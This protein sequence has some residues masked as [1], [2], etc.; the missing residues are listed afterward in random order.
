M[1]ERITAITRNIDAVI[2]S[3]NVIPV[4]GEVNMGHVFGSLKVLRQTKG[5]IE[6]LELKEEEP[7]QEATEDK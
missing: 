6:A 7:A 1:D 5:M 2:N 3:L 4:V